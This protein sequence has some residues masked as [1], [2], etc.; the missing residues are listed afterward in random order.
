MRGER[1]RERERVERRAGGGS[2]EERREKMIEYL[3]EGGI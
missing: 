1:G 3:L 2:G